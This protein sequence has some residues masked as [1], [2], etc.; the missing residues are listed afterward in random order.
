MANQKRLNHIN[1]E[2]KDYINESNF[3]SMKCRNKLLKIFCEEFLVDLDID[4]Y[5]NVDLCVQE[6]FK[7]VYRGDSYESKEVIS[8]M[9]EF[10]ERYQRF[11]ER[12]KSLLKRKD[13]DFQGRR[14]FN[15]FLNL[16]VVICMIFFAI[17]VIILAVR[18]LFMGNY[19]DLLWFFFILVPAI[20]PRFKQSIQNR[21]E[22]AKNYIKS[23]LKK[24]K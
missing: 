1:D 12:A 3:I 24:V 19:F 9:N 13:I 8:N 17:G 11:Q 5:K 16:L 10:E 6:D 20:V 22:Q 14:N 4:N 18:A 7:I 15:N 2:L 21:M 23:L